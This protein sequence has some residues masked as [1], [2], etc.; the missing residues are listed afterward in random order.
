MLQPSSRYVVRPRGDTGKVERVSRGS[1]GLRSL[2]GPVAGAW[3]PAGGE[4]DRVRFSALC[5][6]NREDPLGSFISKT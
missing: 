6:F 4:R 2:R 1:S 5:H 3:G